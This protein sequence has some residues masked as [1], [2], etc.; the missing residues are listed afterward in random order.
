MR[1]RDDMGI[2]ESVVHACTTHGW[3]IMIFARVPVSVG[4]S[5][6]AELGP[7]GC[8]ER[9]SLASSKTQGAVVCVP[10]RGAARENRRR[11]HRHRARVLNITE[12]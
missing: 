10:S 5:S 6:S 8:C 2:E 11:G 4:A 3:I 7:V 12:Y 1:V 9:S